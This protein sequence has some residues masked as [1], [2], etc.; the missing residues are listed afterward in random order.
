MI[1]LH[2]RLLVFTI[3]NRQKIGSLYKG[4]STRGDFTRAED[5][6]IHGWANDCRS[7]WKQGM[8][9]LVSDGF[10]L[11]P[12]RGF[13]EYNGEYESLTRLSK[14]CEGEIVSML[15]A[16][17]SVLCEVSDDSPLQDGDQTRDGVK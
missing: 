17:E 2:R 10:E 9:G 16:E 8:R 13:V 7:Q 6:W 12:T 5:I 4:M 11:E 15:V 1:P 14:E 3:K